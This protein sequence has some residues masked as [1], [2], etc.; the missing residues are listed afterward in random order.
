MINGN[1]ENAN[2]KNTV[3]QQDPSST[4]A[5]P[6]GEIKL[7][8]SEQDPTL[9]QISIPSLQDVLFQAKMCKILEKYRNI[10]QNFDF[11]S[12]VG[13]SREQMSEFIMGNSEHPSPIRTAS[14]PPGAS[15]MHLSVSRSEKVIMQK[16]SAG[17]TVTAPSSP[18]NMSM[19]PSAIRSGLSQQQLIETHKP[20]ISSL[21]EADDLIVEAFYHERH[22]QD[23]KN[24]AYDTG[25]EMP[26]RD[27]FEVAIFKSDAKRQFLVV[28]QGDAD[29]QLKPV[30]KSEHKDGI[31]RRF[32]PKDKDDN[33]FSEE[34]P[35]VVFPP[36][37]KAYFERCSVEDAVFA[38][39][40]ELAEKHP[41]FDVIMTGHSLGG[42]LALLAS[43]RY[44]NARPAIMVSCFAFGCPKIGTLDFR[45]Y[46]NSL[47]NLKVSLGMKNHDFSQLESTCMFQLRFVCVNFNNL[48]VM[49]FE[50]GSDPW[51]FAPE[52][53]NWVHAGHSI[54]IVKSEKE[55]TKKN[56]DSSQ[57]KNSDELLVQ[58]YKFGD[59]MDRKAGKVFSRRDKHVKQHDH[60]I[61]SYLHAFENIPG[62][63][64][65][66][67]FVG[68]EGTGVQGLNKEK[69]LVC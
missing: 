45:Y 14:S 69:R 67:G 68:E 8:S 4:P 44:A 63:S 37:R 15:A 57:N 10:D 2:G 55:K 27:R 26:A 1:A 21:L 5:S 29:S 34:Q 24:R 39:L 23:V 13:M 42:V 62:I 47:P 32:R 19:P 36:F 59:N 12:L 53:P 56:P 43:M 33:R 7:R 60:D 58:A 20:I 64:W 11:S 28:Y 52:H 30:K 51:I 65:P 6:D 61:T 40:D 49:R 66:K 25:R 50:Y 3:D 54:V 22:T 41:F 46:V 17:S 31:D 48:K 35:V 38:K 16:P 9:H 18:S